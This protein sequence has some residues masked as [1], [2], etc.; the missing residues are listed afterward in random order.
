MTRTYDYNESPDSISFIVSVFVNSTTFFCFIFFTGKKCCDEI[1]QYVHLTT[2]K[3]ENGNVT[4]AKDAS[5]S[6]IEESRVNDQS[7]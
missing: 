6:G 2:N 5:H 1:C 3:T 7:N 4:G